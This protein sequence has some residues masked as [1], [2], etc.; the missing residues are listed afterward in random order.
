MDPRNDTDPRDPDAGRP[1]NEPDHEATA[2]L[3]DA[4]GVDRRAP[5][6]ALAQAEAKAAENWS[7]Y[8]RA[9]AELENVRKRAQRDVENARRYGVEKL[10]TELLPV[11]DSLELGLEAGANA[12][13]KTLLQGKEATLKLLS[14][15]LERFEVT[16]INPQ[17]EPFDPQLH[18]AM[19]A[20]ESGTA[21]PDS[22]L[23]VVQKGYQLN[24]RLLR[25]ARVIVAKAPRES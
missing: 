7:S 19:A 18:E 1:D 3:Q 23:Q 13:A 4:P 5:G 22:V 11:K 15:A 10:A 6:D 12:D 8:L 16:E 21:E 9:V 24:G 2:V 14:R 25:P 20:Q 17:G